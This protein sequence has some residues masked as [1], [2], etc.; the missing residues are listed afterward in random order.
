MGVALVPILIV[1]LPLVGLR[2]RLVVFRGRIRTI[3]NRRIVAAVQVNIGHHD[4]LV[5]EH[6]PPFAK[7]LLQRANAPDRIG[8]TGKWPE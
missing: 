6:F 5:G 1:R 2:F 8:P 4:E 3:K 7:H